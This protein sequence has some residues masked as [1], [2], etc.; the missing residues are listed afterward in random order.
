MAEAARIALYS[1]RPEQAYRLVVTAMP[2]LSKDAAFMALA[3]KVG[4][5][6]DRP[7]Q[8][9][10]YLAAAP[11]SPR[12]ALEIRALL[13]RGAPGAGPIP[14]NPSS[15]TFFAMDRRVL[16]EVQALL[17]SPDGGWVVLTRAAVI[18]VG[19]DGH[20]GTAVPLPGGRDLCLD[21]EGRAVALGADHVL[22]G[23]DSVPLSKGLVKA[24]SAAASP[25]GSL[26]LLDG[27]AKRLYRL[28]RSGRVSGSVG[29]LVKDPVKVRLDASGRIYVADENDGTIH[30]FR[31]DMS[32]LRVLDPE[33]SGQKLRKL[34]DLWVDFAG[35]VLVL[36][37]REHRLLLFSSAGRFLG[38]T[39]ETLRVDAAGWDGQ[40]TLAVFDE[41]TGAAG[42]IVL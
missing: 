7:I 2:H 22:W 19:A 20:P 34:T 30:V 14:V 12:T 23:D 38:A 18:R 28:D 42:R 27:G 24:T 40:D 32:P 21:G 11:P 37:G 29:L 5:A 15:K 9:A 16:K 8:A 41:K 35:D 39:P 13:Q 4:I 25:D 6:L 3:A 33:A 10:G 1:G 26:I 36:D 31:G 17:P